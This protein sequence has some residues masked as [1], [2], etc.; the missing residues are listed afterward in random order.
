MRH[1][2]IYFASALGLVV[3]AGL[4]DRGLPTANSTWA[5]APLAIEP[6]VKYLSL[7]QQQLPAEWKQHLRDQ[8]RN[9]R[10]T[11]SLSGG[12]V[13]H[14]FS[15]LGPMADNLRHKGIDKLRSQLA[16]QP[17][18]LG[19]VLGPS[20]HL[21]GADVQGKWVEG[22]GAAGFFQIQRNPTGNQM[23]ELSEN[24][25]DVLGG[26]GT[27]IAP[28]FHNDSVGQFPAT[29]EKVLDRDGTP[30]HNLQWAAKDRTFHLTTR[31]MTADE[32]RQIAAGIT[33]RLM[34]M[35]FEGWRQRYEYDPEN[36]VH[37]TARPQD[38]TRGR[39]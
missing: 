21:V 39:W 7:E 32:T 10:E 26:D 34:A 4:W 37:R 31:N 25:L 35:P 5:T 3:A 38:A 9:L 16:I 17:S 14:E 24:Q 12:K 18:D 28:E 33:Q 11:G 29:L 2:L 8:L 1:R 23:V 30:L 6:G 22:L 36:P 19:R 15:L 20:F 27:V 13:T